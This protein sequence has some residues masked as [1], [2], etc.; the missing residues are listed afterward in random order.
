MQKYE[1]AIKEFKTCLSFGSSFNTARIQIINILLEDLNQPGRAKRYQKNLESSIKG[2]IH[3]VSGLPRSGTSLMMQMLEAG[4]LPV[5]TDKNREADESN[6]KGYYEHD[7]VKSLAKNS[8]FLDDAKNKT[9]KVIAN[10]LKYLPPK[11][12]YKI[13]FMKRNLYEIIQ[14]QQKMMIRDGKRTRLDTLNLGLL[15]QY[16]ITLKETKEWMEK[17]PNI[18]FIE[19]EYEDLMNSSFEQSLLLN[20]FFGD[21]LIPEKMVSIPDV[22]LYRTKNKN[23]KTTAK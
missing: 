4:G 13:V 8:V 21:I 2:T 22:S 1:E 6:P 7:A 12:K 17:Q 3:I 11:Y 18:D 19:V 16:E 15:H 14:S 9:V 20:N 23:E 10:L 5:F